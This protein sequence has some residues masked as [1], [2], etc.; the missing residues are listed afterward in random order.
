[1]CYIY[2]NSMKYLP[3]PFD[4][5]ERMSVGISLHGIA[6]FFL[7]LFAFVF[8]WLHILYLSPRRWRRMRR[9][10]RP[11]QLPFLGWLVRDPLLVLFQYYSMSSV[12]WSQIHLLSLISDWDLSPP[13]SL[14]EPFPLIKA[15][16]SSLC[17]SRT[18]NDLAIVF[19]NC[20]RKEIAKVRKE[21]EKGIWG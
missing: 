8:V 12:A 11:E 2:M 15:F 13:P 9:K 17:A 4:T 3:S 5:L 6:C 18:W 16:L 1:M 20:R 19:E 7:F 10:L 14:S 21:A